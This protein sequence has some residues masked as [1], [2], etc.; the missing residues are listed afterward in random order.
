MQN[1]K[2]T[3]RGFLHSATALSLA[4]AGPISAARKIEGDRLIRVGLIGQDGHTGIILSSLPDIKNAA[5]AAF[6]KSRPEDDAA[7]TRNR[8][9]FTAQTRIYDHYEDM[10][11]KEELDVVGVCLPYYENA[12]ASTEAARRGIHVISEKPVA[13]DLADLAQLEKVIESSGIRFTSMMNMRTWPA[14]QAARR[15]VQEGLIG[16]PILLSSQKSYKFGGSRPWFYRERRT[17]GGSIP[18]VGIHAIDYMR[19]TSRQEYAEVT[20]HHGNKAHPAYPGCE[21][22]AG[23]L[24]KLANGG[25]ALCNL[26]YLRPA[27]ASTHGDDRLRMA[28]SEGVL[29][30]IGS[31][32][33]AVIIS[34]ALPPD[35]SPGASN[36]ASSSGGRELELPAPIDFLADFIAE[37]RGEGTHIISNHDALH[38]TRVCLLARQAAD[39]ARWLSI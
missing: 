22:H 18:W 21:D 35:A 19:W 37:L 20:G 39:Q 36:E 11:E 3:R 4:V 32:E 29:E 31:Q 2:L 6:A 25:T 26:D 34:S 24:L 16:E 30:V 7:W 5:L 17:Y 28:G 38:L 12:R 8:P 33:R 1:F 9:A 10:L 15:A 27:S 14:F 23:V 13:T